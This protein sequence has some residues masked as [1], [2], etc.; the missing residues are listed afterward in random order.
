MSE[1]LCSCGNYLRI[2]GTTVF[3]LSKDLLV[4]K[5]RYCPSCGDEVGKPGSRAA[6]EDDAKRFQTL[7]RISGQWPHTWYLYHH[8]GH[9]PQK[10]VLHMSFYD[11]VFAGRT[12]AEACD[13]A[14]A[15]LDQEAKPGE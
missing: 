3:A 1:P 8:A 15:A 11:D 12:L 9:P 4:W 14:A 5:P 7:V 13:K 10:H 2:V 6:L